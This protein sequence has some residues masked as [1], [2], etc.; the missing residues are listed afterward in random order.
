MEGG[1]I[2]IVEDGDRI[3]IDIPRKRIT[4]KV[5][6]KEIKA[7]LSTW[8]PPRL[9]ISKGYMARYARAVSSGGEGAVVK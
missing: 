8:R 6:E 2:A 9:K 1:P 4:L 7:R 5:S 3:A